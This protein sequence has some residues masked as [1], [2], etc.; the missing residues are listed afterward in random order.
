[1]IWT[2]DSARH[3]NDERIPRTEEQITS[4]NRLAVSKFVEVFGKDSNDPADGLDIPIVPTWGN[5]DILPHNI[6]MKGPNKWTKE[7][8]DV[9]RH[10]IPESQ[11][12]SFEHA[13]WFTVEVIPNK[14]AV[15]SLNSLYFFDNNNAV[16]GCADRNE[17]G[18]EQFEWMRVQL[19]LL[20]QRGMKAIL[21]GHVPPARTDNKMSWDETCW[22][23][24]TLWMRQ[25]RDVVV[26][27]LWGHM[28][29]DHFILQDS[30]EIDIPGIQRADLKFAR[31]TFDEELNLMGAT[32][33]LTDL[34]ED[35][36]K[37]PDMSR[38]LMR[39]PKSDK[40]DKH[41]EDNFYKK[42]GGQYGER[43][44]LGLISPSIVPNYFPTLRIFEYNVS[45]IESMSLF[46]ETATAM[47][48]D[49][50]ESMI[51]DW[52]HFASQ[53]KP[54]RGKSKSK[55][56]KKHGSP[57]V[58]KNKYR[59]KKPKAPSKT[60]PPGPAYSPQTLTWLGY[61]QLFANLTT[62]N[63]DFTKDN[64]QADTEGWK[65]GKHR[66]KDPGRKGKP[67]PKEF[68]FELEYNTRNDTIYNLE[69]LTV[70]NYLELASRI[71][72][73]K[74]K[75]DDYHGESEVRHGE[76]F[77]ELADDTAIPEPD[78]MEDLEVEISKKKKKGRKDRKKK[79][80]KKHHKNRKIINKI[81]YTFVSRAFVS[82]L[83]EEELHDRFGQ[84]VQEEN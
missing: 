36:S 27:S 60:S 78:G 84:P 2:G 79:K 62:V 46:T 6:F 7:F 71:G 72:K 16:D 37:L 69:D 54:K 21:T 41:N 5:N 76:D 29:I 80:K 8:L 33:Y 22:Q 45:G 58:L 17:P 32:D 1:M 42:I 24:Y 15:I 25:Y 20:R 43:Y 66:G 67:N 30:A 49:I 19:Q 70:L 47:E 39:G 18:Y 3:D 28:N 14:L 81:W 73:F 9:W 65:G 48:D 13:G 59:F 35:W 56:D 4:L 40:K 75:K 34:R 52:E 44:S 53:D 64:D 26:G 31:D 50:T 51:D 61:T 11:R 63:N 83:D 68:K 10:F 57:R 74:P 77:T 12:H 82:T 23:K 38:E 55:R